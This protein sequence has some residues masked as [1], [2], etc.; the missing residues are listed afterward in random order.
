MITVIENLI[1][2]VAALPKEAQEEALRAFAEIEAR[3]LGVYR[4]SGEERADI[5][6][7]LV[8]VREGQVAS[9]AE[10]AAVFARLRA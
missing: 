4:L 10:A 8:E 3:H 2:R 7:A 9:D 6:E 1:D 5:L